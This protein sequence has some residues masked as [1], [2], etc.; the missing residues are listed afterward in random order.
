V[1]GGAADA[2]FTESNTGRIG[3][4]TLEGVITE[5]K[6]DLRTLDGNGFSRR[7]KVQRRLGWPS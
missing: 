7:S 1:A 6:R 3:S 2:W 5:Y 4:I